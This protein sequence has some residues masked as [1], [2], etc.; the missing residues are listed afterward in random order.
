MEHLGMVKIEDPPSYL[1]RNN[2][3]LLIRSW[4][5]APH[6]SSDFWNPLVPRILVRSIA[7]EWNAPKEDDGGDDGSGDDDGD[8]DDKHEI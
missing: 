8:D 3:E 1:D 2:W 4:T 7:G 6:V 5:W